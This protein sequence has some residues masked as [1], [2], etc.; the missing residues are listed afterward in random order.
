[1]NSIF[2]EQ[3]QQMKTII[4]LLSL[5]TI[6]QLLLFFI[7]Y[8]FYSWMLSSTFVFFYWYFVSNAIA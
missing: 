2:G 5:L 4:G 7:S 8:V 3:Q 1:M 6:K